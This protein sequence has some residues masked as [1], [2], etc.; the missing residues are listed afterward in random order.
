MSI[1]MI[2]P[3]SYDETYTVDYQEIPMDYQ[4]GQ[5]E[6]QQQ[7]TIASR[8]PEPSMDWYL[9]HAYG[10]THDP[11]NPLDIID[12]SNDFKDGFLDGISKRIR[13]PIPF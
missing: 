1:P 6:H 8:L 10:L 2:Y 13:Y 7:L 5:Q 11:I 4:E 9:G 12:K 3:V